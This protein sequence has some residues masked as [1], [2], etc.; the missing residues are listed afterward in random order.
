M[1]VKR[2]LPKSLRLGRP[3]TVKQ[4]SRGR[5]PIDGK[6]L[7]CSCGAKLFIGTDGNGSLVEFCPNSRCITRLEASA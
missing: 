7:E 6:D 5:P 4:V 3:R 2:A 1:S